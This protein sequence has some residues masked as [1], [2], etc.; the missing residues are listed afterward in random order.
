MNHIDFTIFQWLNSWAGVNSF[1]NGAIVFLATYLWYI[2]MAAVCLFPLLAYFPKFKKYQTRNRTFFIYAV[3]SAVVARFGITEF[4][5]LFLDRPRPFE[6]VEGAHRLVNQAG[7]DA[8]PSGHASLAFAI[9]AAVYFYFP[10][11]GIIFFLAAVSIGF[12]RVAAG[13]HWP[14][15]ILAGAAVGISS[16]VLLRITKLR[17]VQ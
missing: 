11:T 5:R 6:V 1:Y 13:V 10:K 12:G 15:D 17:Y 4:I 16:A 2:V 3:A 8:F 7:G 14:T 9:A